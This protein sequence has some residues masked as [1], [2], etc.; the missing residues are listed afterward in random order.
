MRGEVV[1]SMNTLCFGDAQKTHER[2]PIRKLP[3]SMFAFFSNRLSF[4]S[5][6][7]ETGP[8][9]TQFNRRTH[10]DGPWGKKTNPNRTLLPQSPDDW[11]ISIENQKKSKKKPAVRSILTK[12]ERGSNVTLDFGSITPC[13]YVRCTIKPRK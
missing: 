3:V 11:T 5:E 9:S 6:R 13:D 4:F 2:R 7:P 8:M 12:G 10:G 1:F